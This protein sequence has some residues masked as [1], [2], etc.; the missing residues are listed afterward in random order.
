MKKSYIIPISIFILISSIGTWVLWLSVAP[1]FSNVLKGYESMGNMG[2]LRQIAL[3]LGTIYGG[4][5]SDAYDSK[6]ILFYSEILN[7]LLAL[8]LIFLV[9]TNAIVM[10]P[11]ALYSWIGLRFFLSGIVFTSGYKIIGSLLNEW[12]NSSILHLMVTQGAILF[13]SLLIIFTSLTSLN[14][15]YMSIIFDLFSSLLLVFS[16][17]FMMKELKIENKHDHATTTI[18]DRFLFSLTYF[19]EPR[20]FPW[21]LI[22]LVF[23]IIF[24]GFSVQS[25][26]YIKKLELINTE[27]AF[28]VIT[29]FYGLTFWLTGIF[30]TKIKNDKRLLFICYAT[31]FINP[32]IKLL[33]LRQSFFIFCEL[34]VYIITLCSIL[35]ITNKKIMSLAE[36]SKSGR[37]RSSQ[38]FYLS[39][40]FALGEYFLGI[41]YLKGLAESLLIYLRFIGIILLF[42]ITVNF[43]FNRQGGNKKCRA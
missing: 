17:L 2:F 3:I 31:F 9:L 37:T 11:N 30:V 40:I 42:L 8:F 24:S 4:Y 29:F 26:F 14:T 34:I 38:V 27:V 6:K 43:K 18:N 15:V 7:I 22:Q 21:N 19:W 41:L 33:D 35:H 39:A 20:I 28:S 25:Y 1:N 13:G 36:S 12:G 10:H 16:M 32:L 23:L 5:I